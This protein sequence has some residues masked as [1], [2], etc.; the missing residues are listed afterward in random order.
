MHQLA[1]FLLLLLQ[2]DVICI[3]REAVVH[4]GG[5]PA[6]PFQIKTFRILMRQILVY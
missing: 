4:A 6:L 1:I 2:V 5:T 3:L